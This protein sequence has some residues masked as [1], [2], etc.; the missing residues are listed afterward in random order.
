M[1]EQN[2]MLKR[3]CP[4][5]K[6]EFFQLSK[7]LLDYNCGVHIAHCKQNQKNEDKEKQK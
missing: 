2:Q 1:T 6:K 4:I 3:I 7:K 5:C